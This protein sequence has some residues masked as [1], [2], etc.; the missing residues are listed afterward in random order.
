MTPLGEA[1]RRQIEIAGPMSVADYMAC[2]LYDPGHGYYATH[3]PIGAAGDFTT[4][5]EIS[6]MFGELVAVWLIGAWTASGKPDRICLAEIGPGRGTLSADMMRTIRQLAPD[7][8]Q[9]AEIVLVETSPRLREVQGNTL[10]REGILA[11]WEDR[12]EDLPHNPL[13][14]AGNEIF[15]ALP[16]RQF[17]KAGSAWRERLVGMNDGALAFVAG[18]G[19]I[20]TSLLPADA[21]GQ[22]EGAIFEVAPR[23]EALMQTIAARIAYDGGAGLFFDYGHAEP[24]FGDTF[25]AVKDHRPCGVFDQPG[26]ADLTSHVDFSALAC[27]AR[28]EGIAAHIMEQGAFLLALGVAERAGQLGTGKPADVQR[29]LIAD[30]ERLCG[31]EHM[32]RLFKVLAVHPADLVLPPF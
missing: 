30:V 28:G 21:G 9:A 22:A 1:I 32:G 25:Q 15:D 7:M 11:R 5:P 24:G 10:D 6:Q 18:S 19:G 13:F 4:A 2:C 31:H 3:M 27:A 17:V 20:D 23:R 12:V 26:E 29:S 8:A 16:F 14:V